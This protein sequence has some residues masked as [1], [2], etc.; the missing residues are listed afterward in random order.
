MNYVFNDI[1]LLITNYNRSLSLENLLRTLQKINCTFKEIIVTDDGSEQK[2][3]SRIRSLQRQIPFRLLTSAQNEGAG[4]NMNK[5]QR[6]VKTP[7]TLFV[8]DD[9]EPTSRFPIVLKEALLQLE[10]RQDLDIV[11]FYAYF[12]YPYLKPYSAGFSEMVIPPLAVDYRKVHYYSDH[13]HLRR[14]S[15]LEKFG[16]FSEATPPDQ[17]EYKM[18]ISFI[19]KKGKGL[20]YDDHKALFFHNNTLENSTIQRSTWKTSKRPAVKFLIGIYRQ[21]KHN[22]D[23]RFM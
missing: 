12:R 2:H 6:A 20:F 9:F 18:C 13:P 1:T 3:L 10:S 8:E 4:H 23:I 14:S 21:I 7:Y 22:Y 19:Q 5:G 16:A 15:F 17:T 11:R